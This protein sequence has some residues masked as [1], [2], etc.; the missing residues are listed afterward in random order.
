MVHLQENGAPLA[1][2]KSRLREKYGDWAVITGASD[3]IGREMA[4]SLAKAGLNLMLVARRRALLDELSADLSQKYGIETRVI[5]A[6][7]TQP[8]AVGAVIDAS[9]DLD[10]GLLVACAGF[11]TSGLFIN[12]DLAEELAMIDV[13]CRAVLM[14]S[15]HFGRRFAEQK[16]G[17]LVLMSSLLAFQGVPFVGSLRGDQSLCPVAR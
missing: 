15:R 8:A 3:G 6:D 10:V 16:R 11:G 1:R 7:P 9:R 12:S 13:N 5:D 2:Q 14:M 4:L 17:G